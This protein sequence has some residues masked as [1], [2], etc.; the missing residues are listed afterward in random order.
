MVSLSEVLQWIAVSLAFLVS[1][2]TL[3]NAARLRQ[4]ILAVSTVSFGLGMLSLSMGFLLAISPSLADPETITAVN[5]A[6][7]I[8][9]FFLLGLGSFKIYKMSQIK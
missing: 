8:L 1:L 3:Y 2:L 6:L 4:G 5:Y 7:F 9:G